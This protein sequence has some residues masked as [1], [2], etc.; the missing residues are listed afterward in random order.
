MAW[1]ANIDSKDYINGVL[2]VR[3][4]YTNG[5]AKLGDAIDMTG[6]N[7]D[8]LN[9]K[10]A[11]RLNTL[12]ATDDVNAKISSGSFTPTSTLDPNQPFRNALRHFQSCQRA[13]DLGLITN[14]DKVFTQAFSALQAVYNDTLIDLI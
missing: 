3:V 1:T 9:S 12:N 11:D 5:P 4:L 14:Q 6:G 13:V 10:I 7:I 8:V 2:T